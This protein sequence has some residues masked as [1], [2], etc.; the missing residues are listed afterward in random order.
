[1][2]SKTTAFGR[3]LAVVAVFAVVPPVVSAKPVVTHPTGTV[4]AAGTNITATNVG[5]TITETPLGLLRCTAATMTGSIATNSTEKGFEGNITAATFAGTGSTISGEPDPE[6]TGAFAN[7]SVTFQVSAAAPWCLEGTE[8]SDT[9]RLRGGSCSAASRPL[10]S[11]SVFTIFG[12]PVNSKY[13]RS[14]ASGP[15][16]GTFSTHPED[17]VLGIEN[18]LFT[19]AAEQS[20]FCPSKDEWTM[21]FTVEADTA[22]TGPMYISS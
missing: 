18:Q 14:T 3:D 8:A 6:C 7:W 11:I 13:V 17:A 4:L 15:V 16:S 22:T 10:E 9:F 2:P 20:G 1:M 21:R 19:I 5:E 12:A